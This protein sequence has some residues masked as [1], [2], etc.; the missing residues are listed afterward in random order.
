MNWVRLAILAGLLYACYGCVSIP[1][2]D[3]CQASRFETEAELTQCIIDAEAEL[4]RI[5]E[6]EDRWARERDIWVLCDKVY[7]SIGRPTIHKH[8]HDRMRPTSAGRE[9]EKIRED[10]RTNNCMMIWRAYERTQR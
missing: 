10:I 8:T 7:D 1:T 3:E 6:L 5:Y 4:D 2:V 9:R